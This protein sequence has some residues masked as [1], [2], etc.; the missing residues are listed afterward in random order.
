MVGIAIADNG[1][2]IPDQDRARVFEPFF[3]TKT[4]GKGTGLGLSIV[5]NIVEQHGG[6]IHL[7]ASKLGGAEF[8]CLFRAVTG[9]RGS[10]IP[11]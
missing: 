8:S 10:G 1:P 4:D 11:D 2:G 6:E 9:P 7:G 3:T 5:R